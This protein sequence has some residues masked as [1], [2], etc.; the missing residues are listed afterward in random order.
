MIEPV[1]MPLVVCCNV[2]QNPI[3]STSI[4]DVPLGRNAG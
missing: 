4:T 1:D 2:I 3:V